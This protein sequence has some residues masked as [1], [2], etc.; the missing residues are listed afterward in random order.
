[1]NA[2][3]LVASPV[4]AAPVTLRAMPARSIGRRPNRSDSGPQTSWLKENP[5]RKIVTVSFAV[6]TVVSKV[7]SRSGRI[8]R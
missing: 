6:C 5:R 1:M 8:G 7:R 2:P 3:M 4:S